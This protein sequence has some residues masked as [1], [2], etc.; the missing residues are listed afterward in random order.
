MHLKFIC[1]SHTHSRLSFIVYGHYISNKSCQ[2]F[3]QF[4]DGPLL[5]FSWRVGQLPP[6][7]FKYHL[8]RHRRSSS[9]EYGKLPAQSYFHWS[10]D[11]Q[12]EG[13][14]IC[15]FHWWGVFIFG[16]WEA[17]SARLLHGITQLEGTSICPFHQF[18]FPCILI[19][20]FRKSRSFLV[21]A[22]RKINY[23]FF[24]MTGIR[25]LDLWVI[26]IECQWDMTH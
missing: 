2:L 11:T 10:I 26:G 22:F 24:G 17:A 21:S 6:S 15:P 20:F 16:V 5:Y 4:L 9:L 14:S 12:L 19:P 13:T 8:R 23:K 18:G 1:Y 25:T 7:F 3:N